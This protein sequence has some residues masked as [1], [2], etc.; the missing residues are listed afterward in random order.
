MRQKTYFTPKS[1]LR[2][3][4]FLR[5]KTIL[6]QKR[7]PNGVK[8]HFRP[9]KPVKF[10]FS[11]DQQNERQVRNTLKEHIDKTTRKNAPTGEVCICRRF[12]EWSKIL[13][14]I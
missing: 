8:K 1:F 3:K 10:F 13:Y 12:L 9:Q 14:K 6:R 11:R 2:Q 4:A 7:K 5:Q